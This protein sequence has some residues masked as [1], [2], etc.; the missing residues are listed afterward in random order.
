MKKNADSFRSFHKLVL[1]FVLVGAITQIAGWAMVLSAKF[2]GE[3][4]PAEKS[5][6]S[7]QIELTG[8]QP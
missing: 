8:Q 7:S 1:A 2:H 3:K 6:Q 4:Q 5:W